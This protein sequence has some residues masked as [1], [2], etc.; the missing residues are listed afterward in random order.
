MPD[1]LTISLRDGDTILSPTYAVP[2]IGS[3]GWQLLVRVEEPDIV[4]DQRGALDGWEATPHQRFER[5]LRETGVGAGVL[6]GSRETGRRDEDATEPELRLV[7]A[8]KGETSGWIAWPLP[9]LAT[10]AGREMLGGLKM[11][12]DRAALWTNPPQLRLPNVL[13]ESRASQAGVSS[14]LSGQ[15]LAALHELLR[16]FDAADPELIRELAGRDP[17]QLYEGLLTVLMRLIFILY[18]EDRSLMPSVTAGG[19]AELY[20]RGYSLGGLF[21][22][23][24]DD[25]ALYPDT[26]DER[27]GAW[28]R[29]LALF[30]LVSC[31]HDGFM[32]RRGGR[33]FDETRFPFLLGKA[34]IG[35]ADQVLPVGD[36]CIFRVLTHLMTLEGR[37]G[38]ERLS[39]RTL[40][41]E[42]IG[43][44]YE[45]VMGF[46][47][48]VADGPALAIKAGKND[49]VPVFVDLAKLLAKP[50]GDRIKHLKE[51][52]GRGKFGRGIEAGL[53]A[54][55]T[56]EELTAAFSG[57]GAPR[58]SA[59]DL[60]GSP[61]QDPA[62]AGTPILQPTDERRRTGS[63]YTPRSLTGPIVTHA[64]E[65]VFERLGT[66]ATP[67]QVL[68]LKVCDPAVGSGAFLVEACRQLGSRLVKAWEAHPDLKPSIPADEDDELH[69]RRLVAQRCLY[70]VDR[71]PLALDLAKL[72]L[73]LATLARDHEFNF[74]DHA[75]K[76][77]DSLVGLSR[78]QLSGG[79]WDNA[80]IRNTLLGQ[81][82]G[83]R[84]RAVELHRNAI[85]DAGDDIALAMQ[86]AQHAVAERE[87]ERVRLIGD[88]ITAAFFVHARPRQR[89]EEVR[90]VTAMAGGS[91]WWNGLRN[92][93]L[94]LESGSHPVRPFHWEIEFPEVFARENPGF[95]A[96]V[97]N[98]PFA[99]KNTI[100]GGNRA[101]YLDWLQTLPADAH[102]NADLSAHFYRRA[103]ALL[104]DGGAFGL[105]AT[106]TI[107]Q[108][109]T[110]DSGLRRIIEGGGTIFRAV[111]RHKWEGEAAVVVSLVFVA[112]GQ[113]GPVT[114]NG[115]E[116]RRISAY[117][118]EG[119]LDGSP[120]RLAA[121]AGKVFEG[122]KIY[123]SGFTFD[124]QAAARQ[125][126]TSLEI[127]CDIKKRNDKNERLI[128]PYI[129]GEEVN[130]SPRH[131]HR[132]YVIDFAEMPL[133]RSNELPDWRSGTVQQRALWLREGVVPADYPEPVA[134]DWPDLIEIVER[135]VKPERDKVEREARRKRWWR[136]GDRQPGLYRALS[137]LD[138]ALVISRVSPQYGLA[139]VSS[140]MV[141]ADSLDVFALST[142]AAFATLQSRVHELWA[143]FFASSMKD[144][145]RYTPSDCFETFALP[146]AFENAATLEAA[147]RAYHDYRAQ[148]MVASD[149][150]MTP[151][152]NRFQDS[153]DQA[154]DIVHLRELHARMD[155]AVLTAYGW[156]DLAARAAPD[157]L[158]EDTEDDHTYQ[159]RLFWPAPFRDE[160]LARL[161]RLNEERAAEEQ[162]N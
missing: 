124:D 80:P 21:V 116:V 19:A 75:L 139:K 68:D 41:V 12:L 95:D 153:H 59:I 1:E 145:L 90:Y 84:V 20:E 5:L 144:D 29:L 71:N 96:I 32:Q 82:I 49:K 57:A 106:N 26:M 36:G 141:F 148:L 85:R 17:Q 129:G 91:D 122:S 146:P 134:C 120:V 107:R 3:E 138:S 119:D 13:A 25:D 128:F 157:F 62:G 140:R 66:D 76:S 7:V 159:G 126:G 70:G 52:T 105:I 60:R 47:V 118:V 136:F 115:R 117:L 2:A 10:F 42:Q 113:H 6:I 93:A 100:I 110:R 72:S 86:E 104:R 155:R 30:R 89:A 137:P 103:F 45:T 99:G 22:K 69:A 161:L 133:C 61:R 65:P 127:M 4:L 143:R 121:N 50:A 162:G 64:L 98:P 142:H 27:R 8:P 83:D 15:V 37:A 152:Y 131:L 101:Y 48:E 53:R 158:T 151:T 38:R 33:L 112:K 14:R 46:T 40:D 109:D 150:G 44:V 63:H 11:L 28:G 111:G 35:G 9:S 123:G 147:G 31:G 54:A 74:L 132:R 149:Q 81:Q 24:G 43:S 58:S 16:G 79:S 88:A 34:E 102:G 97:G 78:A 77:G 56:V 87:A 55:V 130:N 108:G 114:L 92:R 67:A 156:D 160:L 73:W 125:M 51:T 135:L 39:Y 154:E 23:L 18:A 94:S